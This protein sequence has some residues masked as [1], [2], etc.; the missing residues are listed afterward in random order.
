MEGEM[1]QLCALL[2]AMETSQR[3]ALD[4][5]DVGESEDED[6]EAEEFEREKAEK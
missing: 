1:R 4:S 2:E 3:I 6:V 5:S